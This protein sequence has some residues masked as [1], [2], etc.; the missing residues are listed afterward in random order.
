MAVVHLQWPSAYNR[1]AYKSTYH[2]ELS[3]CIDN[4]CFS[5]VGHDLM[6]ECDYIGQIYQVSAD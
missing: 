6:H 2:H 4:R 5:Y 3:E 1:F